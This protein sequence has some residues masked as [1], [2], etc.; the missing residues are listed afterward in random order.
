M[1]LGPVSA[2]TQGAAIE[3][4]RGAGRVVSVDLNFR[5][6]LWPDARRMAGLGRD[7]VRHAAVVKMT[8]DEL[9]DIA[10]GASIA[11]CVRQIRHPDLRVCAITKGAAGA[12]LFTDARHL[13]FP[14]FPVDAV[15]TTGAGDA[16]AACLLADLIGAGFDLSLPAR[17][18]EVLRRAS[19][20]GALSTTRKGGMEAMPKP[21]AIAKLAG[22]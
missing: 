14:G 3:I 7:L 2:Q 9:R 13:S 22:R 12:E 17:A 1:L 6:S 15:D 21:A 16:F 11:D 20:A 5:R 8:E 10:T 19:A 4:A 18:D